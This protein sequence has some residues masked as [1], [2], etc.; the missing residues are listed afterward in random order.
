MRLVLS[1]NYQLVCSQI[2][3]DA[4]QLTLLEGNPY[5]MLGKAYSSSVPWLRSVEICISMSGRDD[6]PVRTPCRGLEIWRESEDVASH[7]E[8]VRSSS[9]SAIAIGCWS[10]RPWVSAVEGLVAAISAVD[11]PSLL[12]D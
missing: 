7:G 12:R 10:M 1:N 8:S 2:V 11:S 3:L 4:V 6:V 9:V 5:P